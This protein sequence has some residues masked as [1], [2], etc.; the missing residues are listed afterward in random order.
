M[1]FVPF[2][3]KTTSNPS[4][5]L[6]LKEAALAAFGSAH[7]PSSFPKNSPLG[8]V[9]LLS[10]SIS[11]DSPK[12]LYL[13][14]TSLFNSCSKYFATSLFLSLSFGFPDIPTETVPS[15]CVKTATALF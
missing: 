8:P 5:S 15:L 2:P 10:F 14:S 3:L 6:L 12:T 4:I 7:C 1:L 11:I 13:F 9:G